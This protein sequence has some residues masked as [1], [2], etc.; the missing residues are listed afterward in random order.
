MTVTCTFSSYSI[1]LEDHYCNT[2]TLI[3]VAARCKELLSRWRQIDRR[4]TDGVNESKVGQYTT[5]FE[6]F[7]LDVVVVVVSHYILGFILIF[8]LLSTFQDNTRFMYSLES[9]VRPLYRPH[10]E[11]MMQCLP[12][13]IRQLAAINTTS[14]LACPCVCSYV[15]VRVGACV[16]SRRSLQVKER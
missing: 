10:P 16:Q 9:M 1:F 11:P 4:I 15:C 3:V 14:R 2:C 8:R 5:V 7:F 13:L 6:V 12:K